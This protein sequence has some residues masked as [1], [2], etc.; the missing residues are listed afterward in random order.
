MAA[1][2]HADSIYSARVRAVY[3]PLGEFL[4]NAH[5]TAGPAQLDSVRAAEKSYW[6]IFWEQP[7]IA[8]SI[9]APV[10]RDLVPFLKRML[11]L[12]AKEREGSRYSVGF[13]VTMEARKASAP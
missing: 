1:Q 9:I 4:A 5:G 6:K 12:T 2:Q 8:D 7:E 13:P 11:T 10:Q 3:V